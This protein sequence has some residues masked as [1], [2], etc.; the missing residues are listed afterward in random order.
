MSNLFPGGVCCPQLV[1]E[2]VSKLSGMVT[3]PTL[4]VSGTR[5]ETGLKTVSEPPYQMSRDSAITV[6]VKAA[7]STG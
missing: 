3:A 4:C 6:W 2:I 7:L 5:N 1:K